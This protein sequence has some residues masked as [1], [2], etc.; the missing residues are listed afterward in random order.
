MMEGTFATKSMLSD[1]SS[2]EAFWT[3]K[4]KVLRN[5][6]ELIDAISQMDEW[7]FKYHVNS[8]HNKNDFADWIR[9]VFKEDNL[10]MRLEG[11]TDRQKYLSII[12]KVISKSEK[13]Q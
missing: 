3:V 4:G 5:I 7:E 9:D 12:K 8:D 13:A 1:C 11:V 2:H 6:Y 10:S